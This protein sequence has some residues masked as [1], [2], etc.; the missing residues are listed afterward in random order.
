MG[1]DMALPVR[2]RPRSYLQF[3][4]ITYFDKFTIFKFGIKKFKILIL[5][6]QTY[7]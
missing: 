1:S 7:Q 6:T 2:N 5:I 3:F 4:L